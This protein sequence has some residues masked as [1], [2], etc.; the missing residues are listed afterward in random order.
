MSTRLSV[1]S[2][3]LLPLLLCA[4]LATPTLAVT[5]AGS[6]SLRL[7]E[8]AAA[9]KAG[10][11]QGEVQVMEPHLSRPGQPSVQVRYRGWPARVFL[12]RWLGKGW[13][14][15]EGE[16]EFRAQDGFVSRIPVERF[17]RHQAWVVTGRVDGQ[18]FQVDNHAQGEKQVPLGPYYL[19]WDNLAEPA[20]QAE[21]G[22]V[23]PYQV[24]SVR[25]TPSS[26]AALLPGAMAPRYAA[27]AQALQTHCLSCHQVNGYGGDK[28][29]LNLAL[30]AREIDS[31]RWSAWLLQP[32]QLKPGTTMPPLSE[33]LPQAEREALAQQLQDYLKALPL[34]P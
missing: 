3:R 33:G 17:Q 30:R 8:P 6:A 29:P 2:R 27:Q 18:A 13:D 9:A 1:L 10:P 22:A 24:V 5:P 15:P 7:P 19:V 23:W 4:S 12:D 21:G 11:A 34:Q 14:L 32:A 20:L 26:R 31:K 16:L 28:M 25:R